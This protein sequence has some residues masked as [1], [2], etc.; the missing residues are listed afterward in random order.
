MLEIKERPHL[1]LPAVCGFLSKCPGK[2]QNLRVKRP[3]QKEGENCDMLNM[4]DAKFS[5]EKKMQASRKNPM[6]DDGQPLVIV[7]KGSLC[8]LNV[9]ANVGLPPDAIYNTVTDP[10]NKSVFKN[11]QGGGIKDVYV[12]I[13]I[14][15]CPF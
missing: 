7:P 10:D 13:N 9:K 1:N 4:K 8:Q 14:V 11:I 2:N 12:P 5:L 15:P 3:T 6:W